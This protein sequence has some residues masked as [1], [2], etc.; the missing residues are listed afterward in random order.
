MFSLEHKLESPSRVTLVGFNLLP[1]LQ[2]AP[3][4]SLLQMITLY[5][6]GMSNLEQTV[7]LVLVLLQI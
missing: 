1:S 6:S 4:L 3:R 7:V 5:A 2:M